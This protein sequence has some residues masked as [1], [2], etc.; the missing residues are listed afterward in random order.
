MHQ[1]HIDAIIPR[2]ILQQ[3]E[4][5]LNG[6]IVDPLFDVEPLLRVLVLYLVQDDVTTIRDEM[7]LHLLRH[8]GHVGNPRLGVPRV[9]V[10]QLAVGTGRDPQREAAGVGLGVDVWTGSQDHVQADLLGECEELRE[11][12]C[13]ALEVDDTGYGVVPAPMVVYRECIEPE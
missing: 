7:R 11:V 8:L 13:T 2:I 12:V 4:I 3:L 9:V 1:G 5:L 6:D 10:P